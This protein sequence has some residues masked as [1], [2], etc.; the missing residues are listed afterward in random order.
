M[1]SGS[2]PSRDGSLDRFWFEFDWGKHFGR[3]ETLKLVFGD[4]LPAGCGVTGYDEND[5]RRLWSLRVFDGRPLRP[6]SRVIS[7]VDVDALRR[8]GKLGAC[9]VTAWRGVWSPPL[10]LAEPDPAD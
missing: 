5:C 4:P 7:E 3:P 10:N 9:G 2:V 1:A 8:E 6:L